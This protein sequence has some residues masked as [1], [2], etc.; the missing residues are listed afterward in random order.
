VQNRAFSFWKIEFA[1]STAGGCDCSV[2]D[3]WSMQ[4]A[5]AGLITIPVVGFLL[6]LKLPCQLNAP[7]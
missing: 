2:A 7:S 6:G 1:G 5:F 4:L 3:I